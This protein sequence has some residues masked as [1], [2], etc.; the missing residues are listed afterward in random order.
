VSDDVAT[1]KEQVGRAAELVKSLNKISSSVRKGEVDPTLLAKLDVAA[2]SGPRG[3][4]AFDRSKTENKDVGVLTRDPAAKDAKKPGEEGTRPEQI[5]EAM[6]K[7]DGAESGSALKS[8]NLTPDKIR[9]LVDAGKLD[10]S[11]EYR[12]LIERYFAELSEK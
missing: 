7:P 5:F 12:R 9:K 3:G 8:G 11:P 1:L 6:R 4:E 10:V 2:E